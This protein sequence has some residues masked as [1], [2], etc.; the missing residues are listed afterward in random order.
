MIEVNSDTTTNG[1]TNIPADS[2]FIYSTPYVP[3][4]RI[5]NLGASLNYFRK[6]GD[7]FN[8]QPTWQYGSLILEGSVYLKFMIEYEF[9]TMGTDGKPNKSFAVYKYP[10][11]ITTVNEPLDIIEINT[12]KVNINAQ[13]FENSKTISSDQDITIK[14]DIT[15][16]N[17]AT[18]TI[19][20]ADNLILENNAKLSTSNGGKIVIKLSGNIIGNYDFNPDLTIEYDEYPLLPFDAEIP[21]ITDPVYLENF[22]K[23]SQYKARYA[24]GGTTKAQNKSSNKASNNRNVVLRE[25]EFSVFPNPANNQISVSFLTNTNDNATIYIRDISGKE[26]INLH[27]T[28]NK[29]QIFNEKIDISTLTQGIYILTI[30]TN[31]KLKTFKIIKQ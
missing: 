17:G 16:T 14:G 3:L 24:K 8:C 13:T 29:N 6:Y 22:C 4:N 20:T 2:T 27:R 18:L 19:K 25:N 28:L 30:R 9:N 1:Y 21:P 7:C 11:D 31:Y 23:S 5:G 15:V 12:E 10:V 26:Y